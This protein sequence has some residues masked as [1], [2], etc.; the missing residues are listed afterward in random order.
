MHECVPVN[1]DIHSV[2]RF[3]SL[4]FGHLLEFIWTVKRVHQTAFIVLCLWV[5]IYEITQYLS[6]II[7]QVR[8]LFIQIRIIKVETTFSIEIM[9]EGEEYGPQLIANIQVCVNFN[10]NDQII[11]YFVEL[12]FSSL[13]CRLK[14]SSQP[15]S[16]NYDPRDS[17]RSIHWYLFPE[18]D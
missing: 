11:L 14:E 2:Q 3:V 16:P 12:H 4:R 10:M 5:F 13:N 18:K 8:K 1:M 9:A 15:I 7:S 17:I 6:H